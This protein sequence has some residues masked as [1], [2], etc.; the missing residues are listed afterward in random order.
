[1]RRDEIKP[2]EMK[3]GFVRDFDKSLNIDQV[4][5]VFFKGPRSYT[6]QDT[7]ELQG[8]GGPAVLER[9]MELLKRKGARQAGPGEFTYRAFRNG[10]M[11]LGQAEAVCKLIEAGNKTQAMLALENLREGVGGDIDKI[12][13][14]LVEAA[15]VIDAA[16]DFPDEMEEIM[17]EDFSR[18]IEKKAIL[19]LRRMI[20]TYQRNQIFAS[21]ASVVICGRPNV[22][23]SSLFNA[24]LGRERA[25]VYE[26]A[27]TTRDSL[28]EG[29]NLDGVAC[30]IIDTAGIGISGEE[31]EELG[32]GISKEKMETADL[33]LV[34]L[35]GSQ[36][37]MEEDLD[38]LRKTEDVRRIIAVNKADKSECWKIPDEV[39]K[40]E[41]VLGLS[42]K[43]V[44]GLT[45]LTQAIRKMLTNGQAD[46][47][48]GR[49]MVN[50]RQVLVMERCLEATRDGIENLKS[51]QEKLEIASFEINQA[52]QFLGEVDGRSAPEMVLE[53]IF[54]TFCVG[55]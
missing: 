42:A 8:H 55:K 13:S 44:S 22:G 48:P 16:I 32:M 53:K 51:G 25:L 38:I 41:P 54:S 46:P 52:L 40:S 43:K 27:G 5:W 2:N 3:L 21:G 6:G 7:V 18:E 14:C 4:M 35:D 10:K 30:R 9:T 12:R 19:P 29:I 15:A 37:L 36:P 1:M 39:R 11:D 50:Q 47:M 49:A 34:V 23:K 20:D 28:E 24:I 17:P 31:V 45:E 26:K 33:C